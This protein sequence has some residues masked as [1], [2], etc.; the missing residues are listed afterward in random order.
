MLKI[1]RMYRY[2]DQNVLNQI[3][4][5]IKSDLIL[6]FLPCSFCSFSC[7]NTLYKMMSTKAK[8]EELKI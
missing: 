4:S 7:I 2:M 8:T 5:N 1:M 3:A 6:F